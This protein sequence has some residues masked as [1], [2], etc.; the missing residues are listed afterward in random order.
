MNPSF[1][2]NPTFRA[3]SN[4]KQEFLQ[5]FAAQSMAG[6]V[7]DLASQLSGAATEARQRGLQFSDVETSLLINMLK[8][9]MSP[10]EQAKADRMIQLVNTFKPR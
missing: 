8:E 6:N 10:A 5:A 4:E 9:N 2:N 7:N 3:L 1:T